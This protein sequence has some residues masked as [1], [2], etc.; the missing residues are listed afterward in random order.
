MAVLW[1]QQGKRYTDENGKNKSVSDQ[2]FLRC[3]VHAEPFGRPRPICDD[4]VFARPGTGYSA[5]MVNG[6]NPVRILAQQ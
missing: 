1:C 5:N 6:R 2:F 4:N 3:P